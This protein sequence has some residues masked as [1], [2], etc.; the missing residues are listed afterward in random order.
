MGDRPIDDLYDEC[1][2]SLMPLLTIVSPMTDCPKGE[3]LLF[4]NKLHTV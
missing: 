3:D 1:T 2:F 4:I